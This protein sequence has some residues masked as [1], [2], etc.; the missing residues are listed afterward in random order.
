MIRNLTKKTTIC[1]EPRFARGF[2]ERGIGM[3]GHDFSRFDGM[4]FEHCS[5]I[6]TCFMQIPLDVLFLDRENQVLQIRESLRPW[7]PV[8]SCRGGYTVMELPVGVIQRSLTKIGDQ[9]DLAA[10]CADDTETA[11]PVFQN[12]MINQIETMST[13]GGK[14]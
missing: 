5:S 8:V 6:H 7:I 10:E 2:W 4:I 13:S 12:M 3:I 1:V 14:K 9:L 11:R